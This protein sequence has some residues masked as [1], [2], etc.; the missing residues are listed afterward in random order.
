MNDQIAQLEA[1]KNAAYSE[2]NQLVALLSK[3]F[4]ASLE[5]H[6][7]DDKDWEDDWRW[8]V[9]INLPS[10]QATWHIHDSELSL[11]DHLPREQGQRWDG[12]STEQK[13]ERCRSYRNDDRSKREYWDLE[14]DNGGKR[15]AS[16]ALQALVRFD[17]RLHDSFVMGGRIEFWLQ[18]Q[19]FSVFTRIS[20]PAGKKDEF[21]TVSGLKLKEPP[22]VQLN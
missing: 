1:A 9:F 8:I 13:Y 21:E 20:L 15:L 4:P 10:G 11:F 2:R 19:Y 18:P 5:R 16:T 12:H 17:G 22:R 3:V 7:E 6:P 14:L